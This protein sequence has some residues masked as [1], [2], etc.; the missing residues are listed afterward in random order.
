MP[1]IDELRCLGLPTLAIFI[2]FLLRLR[3]SLPLP[4]VCRFAFRCHLLDLGLWSMPGGWNKDR[5]GLRQWRGR[6]RKPH[7]W[8]KVHWDAAET[9]SR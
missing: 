1:D 9:V 6:T 3:F 7:H 8:K 2:L 5:G 4:L